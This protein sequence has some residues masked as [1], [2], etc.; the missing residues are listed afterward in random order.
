MTVTRQPIIV[1]TMVFYFVVVAAIGWWAARRTRNASDFFAASRGIGLFPMTMAAMAASL[2]GFAFIGGPGLVYTAGIGALYLLLPLSLTTTMTAWAL[3]SQ[4]RALA[5][6]HGAY[7]IP[8]AIGIRYQSP[9]AQGLAGVSLL[10]AV[11]GYLAT[12]LLALGVVL[13]AVLGVSV[14][15]GVWIG[16]AITLGYSVAGGALAGVYTDVFQ[17]SVM[18]VASVLVFGFA[19][20]AGAGSTGLT[21]TILASDPT[22]LGPVGTLNPMAALSLFFVFGIGA[23]GQPHVIH[24][25]YMIKD[26]QRLRWYPAV[27]T[28]AMVMTVLLFVGVGLAVKAL[29][30][31]GEMPA[32]LRADD[33][34]PTFLT[35][36]APTWLAG[37]V[38]AGVAAAIMSSVNAF[39]TIGAAAVTHDIPHAF[40]RTVNDELRWGRVSTVVIT[41]LAALVASRSETLV[42]FLGIFGWGLFASTLVPALAIGLNWSGGTRPAAIASMAAGL[43]T[44][45]VLESLAFLKV[46]AFPAGVTATA[47]ALVTSMLVYLAVSVGWKPESR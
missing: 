2:S 6:S 46:F 30:V 34:T 38:F 15:T 11:I 4:L 41:V 43:L 37:L 18:A 27:M 45:L 12:N 13:A 21:A 23:M 28:L 26:P 32:L 22:F 8:D 44:T 1:V 20:K 24:K 40:G 29:V 35:R 36:F 17:G 25:F 3:A 5:E 42:A 14:T 19:M 33:A 7:T 10:V 31:R 39:L 16:T 9:G 47:L